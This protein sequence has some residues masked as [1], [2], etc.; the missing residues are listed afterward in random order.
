MLYFPAL[1]V[2]VPYIWIHE[3]II[4]H[5]HLYTLRR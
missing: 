5:E 1:A 4:W 3:S 2:K